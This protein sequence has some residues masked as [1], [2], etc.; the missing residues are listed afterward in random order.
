M[1]FIIKDKEKNK[2]KRVLMI[3]IKR[4]WPTLNLFLPFYSFVI[5]SFYGQQSKVK[6][7]DFY[8]NDQ[9]KPEQLPKF[10]FRRVW[11]RYIQICCWD[12]TT[13]VGQLNHLFK[14]TLW[15][16]ASQCLYKEIFFSLSNWER[17]F[18]SL[19]MGNI[20]ML[21][22]RENHAKEIRFET[23]KSFQAGFVNQNL[24]VGR[25]IARDR[26]YVIWNDL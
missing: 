6:H 16:L 11:W 14:Q 15:V 3:Q 7:L 26:T 24:Y 9:Q 13:V 17:A 5:F 2:R 21:H 23:W 1:I 8:F 4:F 10:C 12:K 25:Y 18:C 20:V 19:G 22:L